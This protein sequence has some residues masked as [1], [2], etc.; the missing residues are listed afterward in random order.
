MTCSV[1]GNQVPA[2]DKYCDRCGSAAP[3]ADDGLLLR[4][5]PGVRAPGDDRG[6]VRFQAVAP[7]REVPRRPTVP[8]AAAPPGYGARA[9]GRMPFVLAMDEHVLK[10]YEAVQLR[11]GLFKARRGHGS[12]YV[13]DA[14]VVFSAWVYPRGAQRESWL[15][16]TKLEDI[17]GLSAHVLRRVSLILLILSTWFSVVALGSL[18]VAT[19][20]HA[21]LA[22][23]LFFGLVAAGFIAWLISSSKRRGDVG[24]LIHSREN[25]LSPIGFGHE[26]RRGAL[27][28]RGWALLVIAVV[29]FPPLIVFAL[30][31]F[32]LRPYSVWDVVDGDPAGDTSQLLAELGALILDLQTRGKLAYPH[33]GFA[34]PGNDATG[35][36]VRAVT[37]PRPGGADRTVVT[38]LEGMQLQPRP[39][40]GLEI[41]D[42]LAE[43]AP[44]VPRRHRVGEDHRDE[45]PS[46][47]AAGQ[48]P[49]RRR[50]HRL[51]HQGR[52]PA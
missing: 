32:L 25:G 27:G 28:K 24:V 22:A 29:L 26:S 41:D 2:A 21:F 43:H 18:I 15:F 9:P 37:T 40:G 30:I 11:A 49:P 50:V 33:W 31:F 5:D 46:P 23:F 4:P 42:A 48:E 12:L 20:I 52:L 36:G 7:P 47:S 16:Q 34:L 38:V 14:R 35:T 44:A 45:A 8:P 17:S 13:T 3:R 6:P 1:C 39:P 10:S 51:R 19:R